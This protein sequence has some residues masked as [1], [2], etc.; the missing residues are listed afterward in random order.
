MAISSCTL[1]RHTSAHQAMVGTRLH[2]ISIPYM[3][4]C[5]EHALEEVVH[6]FMALTILK[7]LELI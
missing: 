4:F 6:E 1:T 3:K 5:Y 7:N 2:E